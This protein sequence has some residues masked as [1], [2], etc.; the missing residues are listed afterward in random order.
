MISKDQQL[1]KKKPL[2]EKV[3]ASSKCNETFI[4]HNAWHKC[5]DWKCAIDYQKEVVA[6]RKTKENNRAKKEF[7]QN[8]ISYMKKK[9]QQ[10]FNQYIR[11]R[12]RWKPCISCNEITDRQIHAGHFMPVGI[13]Q[14]L[15]FDEDNCHAQCSICNNHK[16]GNLLPYEQN[17]I[18]KIGQD[19][20]DRLKVKVTK[21]W[22]LEDLKE[23]IETYK[24]KIKEIG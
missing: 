14:H 19:K 1:K 18:K 15:R 12:D 2:K 5:H 23:I 24:Q 20:V 16:S 4:P 7:N 3:C 13:N 21:T 8:D 11:L 10:I 9:A 6:K 22:T 17:L